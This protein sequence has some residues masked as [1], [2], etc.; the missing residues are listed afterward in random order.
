MKVLSYMTH[1]HDMVRNY[2]L[3]YCYRIC[4]ISHII[5]WCILEFVLKYFWTKW[6]QHFTMKCGNILHLFFSF[7]IADLFSFVILLSSCWSLFEID[8]WNPCT[9]QQN[10]Y[11]I[12]V[13]DWQN[14]CY[15]W[16]VGHSVCLIRGYIHY[17]FVCICH[18]IMSYTYI[19]WN[20]IKI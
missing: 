9:W 11:P 16:N 13:L 5:V 3:L 15:S 17:S 6:Q 2:F 20:E 18:T 12:E 1:K 8:P 19:L 10:I 7:Q 4:H 14:A